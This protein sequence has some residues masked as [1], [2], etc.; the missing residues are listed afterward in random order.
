M[1]KTHRID[2]SRYP[3]FAALEAGSHWYRNATATSDNTVLS[4]P[5]LLTGRYLAKGFR[6]NPV[7]IAAN[8]PD[9]LFTLLAGNYRLNVSERVTALCPGELCAPAEATL[10]PAT[11]MRI[12]TSDLTLLYLHLLLPARWANALPPVDQ[13]WGKFAFVDAPAEAP[14]RPESATPLSPTPGRRLAIAKESSA[15]AGDEAWSRQ[16]D[17]AKVRSVSA[18][19][20]SIRDDP[21]REGAE[22]L[23]FLHSGLPH[24]PWRYLPSGNHYGTQESGLI[25]PGP[26]LAKGFW[27]EDSWPVLQAFQRYLLQQAFVDRL[28]GDLLRTLKEVGLY[29]R[30]LLI[31][32]ADH[33]V[34]FQ[35]GKHRRHVDRQN[36]ADVMAV[37]LFIKL[38][39]QR[40]GVLSDRNV[41]L[42]DVLPTIL[43]V[44]ELEMPWP[45]DGVSVFDTTLPER[46][47]KRL[48]RGRSR[49]NRLT[50]DATAMEEKY[51]TVT[52]M[53]EAFGPSTEPLALYRIGP[54]SDLL[55]RP[56]SEL[57]VGG[58][59]QYQVELKQ[60]ENFDHVDPASGFVPARVIGHLR[61]EALG[62]EPLALAIAVGGTVWATTYTLKAGEA[63]RAQFTAMVPERAWV[64]GRNPVEV[65]VLAGTSDS[66]RLIPTRS[67]EASEHARHGR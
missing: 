64:A 14:G 33:G 37:P 11:R 9:N 56:L 46:S 4:V 38:P 24:V 22:A 8:Y 32:T 15:L 47:E 51:A 5:T 35:P 25:Q 67:G 61:S 21:G 31:V 10:A 40:E 7:P 48:L 6:K 59:A 2:A 18:F 27:L 23:H 58:P 17:G 52:R 12:L 29:D 28:L 30:A 39:G 20:A 34:S 16:P 43:D 45:M 1:D 63:S 60:P 42:V 44:L 57:D 13:Q 36:F 49:R 66:P 50:F 55:G 62:Q 41:E 53:F 3:A 19:L 54:F 65:L 26:G